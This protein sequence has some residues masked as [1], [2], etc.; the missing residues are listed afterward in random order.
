MSIASPRPIELDL[1]C[2]KLDSNFSGRIVGTGNS[3]DA[4]RSNFLSKAI[5]AFVLCEG[6]AG[7]LALGSVAAGFMVRT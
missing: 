4:R 7:A 6:A 5:A 3:P 2:T 1:L